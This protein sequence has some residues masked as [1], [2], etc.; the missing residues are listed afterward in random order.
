MLFRRAQHCHVNI[1]AS[2]SVWKMFQ[3][4]SRFY[5]LQCTSRFEL[6]S[7]CITDW[8]FHCQIMEGRVRWTDRLDV[9]TS[10]V[11]NANSWFNSLDSPTHPLLWTLDRE[12]KN[13]VQ[14]KWVFPSEGVWAFLCGQLQSWRRKKCV[15][16]SDQPSTSWMPKANWTSWIGFHV[17]VEPETGTAPTDRATRPLFH[18]FNK[19]WSCCSNG[20]LETKWGLVNPKDPGVILLKGAGSRIGVHTVDVFWT[21]GGDRKV[22]AWTSW[23]DGVQS[24]SGIPQNLPRKT[25]SGLLWSVCITTT[26]TSG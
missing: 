4:Y 1:P 15:L 21:F 26:S 2:S 14:P 17:S 8:E 3:L 10:A 12:P 22:R 24:R 20:R 7:R 9:C 13:V 25:T 18:C 6:M 19:G 23:R 16:A 11:M 5:F